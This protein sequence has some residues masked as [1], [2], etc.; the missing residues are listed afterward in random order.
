MLDITG[1]GAG[2]CV[3]RATGGKVFTARNAREIATMMNRVAQDAMA[4]AD[5]R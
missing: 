1:T 4:P 3:A 2:N 5:C